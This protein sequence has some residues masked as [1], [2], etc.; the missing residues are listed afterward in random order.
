MEEGFSFDIGI[1]NFVIRLRGVY[2]DRGRCIALTA[3]VSARTFVS[4]RG[5]R[6]AIWR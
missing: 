3:T 5:C 2:Q 4:V 1:S 6:G